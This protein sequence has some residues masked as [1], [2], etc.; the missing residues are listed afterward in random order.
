[1]RRAG[2]PTARLGVALQAEHGR[3]RAEHHVVHA[4]PLGIRRAVHAQQRGD[5]VGEGV[6]Q[7]AG[8]DPDA[9]ADRDEQINGLVPRKANGPPH[10]PHLAAAFE[11]I[12]MEQATDEDHA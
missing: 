4:T 1:M 8:T 10:G 7:P 11:L 9:F 2:L 6:H 12:R 5:G 3:I